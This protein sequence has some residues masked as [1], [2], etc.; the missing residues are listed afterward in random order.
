MREF[1]ALKHLYNCLQKG[2]KPTAKERTTSH[3]NLVTLVVY[4]GH[5]LC[6]MRLPRSNSMIKV[7][8]MTCTTTG[9]AL[10]NLIQLKLIYY[11]DSCQ[12]TAC[13]TKSSQNPALQLQMLVLDLIQKQHGLMNLNLIRTFYHSFCD[14]RKSTTVSLSFVQAVQE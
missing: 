2:S 14:R 13:T 7:Q 6:S 4:Q 11:L 12:V 1:K 5:T 9:T 10:V 8:E 3:I